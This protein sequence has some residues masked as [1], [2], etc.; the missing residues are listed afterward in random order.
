MLRME[1]IL[2]P[3]E[4]TKLLLTPSQ[5]N[6]SDT[7][8]TKSEPLHATVL[9]PHWWAR[10]LQEGNAVVNQFATGNQ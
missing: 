8:L 3:P 6:G 9:Q 1:H 4:Q 7:Q 10:Y 2:T 5:H